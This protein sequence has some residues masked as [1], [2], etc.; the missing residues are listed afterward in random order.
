MRRREFLGLT[1]GWLGLNIVHKLHVEMPPRTLCI[2]RIPGDRRAVA[3]HSHA[4]NGIES[5][6]WIF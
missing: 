5:R 6:I 1:V 4:E 2:P 3:E